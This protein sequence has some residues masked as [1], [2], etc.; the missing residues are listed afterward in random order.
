[1]KTRE[2]IIRSL[3]ICIDPDMACSECAYCN[4]HNGCSQL[5]KDAFELFKEMQAKPTTGCNYE[6]IAQSHSEE[7][8][9]LNDELC[10]VN[11]EYEHAQ[12]ELADTRRELIHLRTVK[13]TAEAFWGVKIN[14]K[15]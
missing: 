15:M 8:R 7:I 14:G 5:R 11:V 13:A 1:M 12:R 2:E 3:G 9:K 10:R 4:E 6:A